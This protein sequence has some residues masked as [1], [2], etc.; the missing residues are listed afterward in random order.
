MQADRRMSCWCLVSGSLETS[1]SEFQGHTGIFFHGSALIKTSSWNRNFFL[2]N[3]QNVERMQSRRRSIYVK[4]YFRL[5]KWEC[6]SMAVQGN[7]ICT[8]WIFWPPNKNGNSS[9]EKKIK[10]TRTCY[11]SIQAYERENWQRLAIIIWPM[12][13]NILNEHRYENYF[14]VHESRLCLSRFIDCLKEPRGVFNS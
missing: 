10:A 6:K 12:V 7:Y 9:L 11:Q 4:F 3:R 14:I 2:R 5:A 13:W 8:P 1:V